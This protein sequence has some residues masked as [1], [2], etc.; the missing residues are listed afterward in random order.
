MLE[1]GTRNTLP[2]KPQVAVYNL[3]RFL[4]DDA[5]V[6]SDCGTV[7]TWA[8]RYVEIRGAMKFSASGLLATMA[9]AVP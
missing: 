3:N 1:Q 8:A 7:T 4:T 9:N 5:I 6:A 2:M